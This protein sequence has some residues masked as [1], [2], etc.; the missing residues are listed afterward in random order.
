[1]QTSILMI[2]SSVFYKISISRIDY[3]NPIIQKELKEKIAEGFK[4]SKFPEVTTS[5]TERKLLTETI[6]KIMIAIAE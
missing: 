3:D 4:N 1:M 2:M 5:T 6:D